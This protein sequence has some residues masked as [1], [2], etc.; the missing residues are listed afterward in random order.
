MTN[1]ETHI[2]S[3]FKIPDA[4][5]TAVAELFEEDNLKKGDYY[6]RKDVHCLKMSFQTNGYVRIFKTVNDK[7]ITQ[8]INTEGHFLTDLSSFIFGQRAQ[9]QMQA[10]TDCKLYTL[11]KNNYNK[12]AKRV[13]DW[14]AIEKQFLAACFVTME[15]RIFSHLSMTAEDRYHRLYDYNKDLFSQVPQQYIASML[16]MTPET[17]SRI[18]KKSIS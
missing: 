3:V 11:S 9:W 16:G 14:L 15:N 4:S 10:L 1:L 12:L 8:W 7:E 6:L 13:P 5:L 2:Q 17:F 18:R